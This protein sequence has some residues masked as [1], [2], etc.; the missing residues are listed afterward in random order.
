MLPDP[1][2][3]LALFDLSADA[4]FVHTDTGRILD[5]N[6]CACER[7]GYRLEELLAM[8]IDEIDLECRPGRPDGPWS[9]LKVGETATVT[10]LMQ[11]KDGV[12]FP[13]EARLTV[14]SRAPPG[15]FLAIVQ[16]TSARFRAERALRD[17]TARAAGVL[18]ACPLA[19]VS[20]DCEGRVTSWNRAAERLLGWTAADAVGEALPIGG[21]P[22]ELPELAREAIGGLPLVGGELELRRRDASLVEVRGW[23][24]TLASDAEGSS[25]AVLV[26]EDLTDRRSVERELHASYERFRTYIEHALDG[27]LV[28]DQA[29]RFVD[30]NPAACTLYGYTRDELLALGIPEVIAP[31]ADSQEAAR[32]HFARVLMTGDSRG[33]VTGLRKDGS[34]FTTEIRAVT[35]GNGLFLGFARDVTE[36][37][38]AE[39]QVRLF[40]RAFE[41]AGE[42]V[43]IT[44]A[45]RRIVSVNRAF[46]RITGYTEEEVLGKNP[47][48][49]ASGLHDRHFYELMWRT[50]DHEGRWKGEIWNR[51]KSG[52]V[53]P[54]WVDISVVKDALGTVESYIAIFSDISER[55]ASEERI[56]FLSQHDA[57]TQLPNRSLFLDRLHQALLHAQ[58]AGEHVGLL[59][60]DLDRFKHVNDS[61]GHQVGDRLL[62]AVAERLAGCLRRE[63]TAARV[64]GDEFA[65]VIPHLR[66]AAHAARV[67]E[68]VLDCLREP[69]FHSGQELCVTPSIGIAVYP[70]DGVE[71][72]SLIQGSDAAMYHVKQSGRNGYRFFAAD[73]QSHAFERMQ[74]ENELRHAI[75]DG[76]LTLHFQP[77]VSLVTGA[78]TGVEA[79]IRWA[80]PDRGLVPPDRFV[81]LAEE[82]GLVSR[83]GDWVLHTACE[84]LSRWRSAGLPEITVAV[85]VSA[86]QLQDVGIAARIERILSEFSVDPGRIELELTESALMRDVPQAVALVR[87][88]HGMGLRLAVDDF[89]TGYSNLAYL[90]RFPIGKLKIDKGFVMGLPDDSGD[91][92]IVESLI[93]LAHGLGQ[94]V[95]AEGV[96]TERQARF[97]QTRGCD[98]LQGFYFSRPV[99]DQDLQGML[100]APPRLELA[101]L[102]RSS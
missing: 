67:A 101:A 6:A 81:P 18:A 57:L 4:V 54:E 50:L 41:G 75:D 12:T 52:Q 39:R 35:L 26:F 73:M 14:V 31:D 34:T 60:I 63:D 76:Q 20:V 5:A 33:D 61:M 32:A 97:L 49:L 22:R 13:A 48:I 17:A 23:S 36:Q 80:H 77:Q 25:G 93:R 1:T 24:A 84:H 92:A 69:H 74:L 47:R 94:V 38:G 87:E 27:V 90:K 9:T 15:V 65:V 46:S 95:L 19:A 44:D 45:E 59:F 42:A 28:V 16:D 2:P 11:R 82:C 8:S 21:L 40:A 70:T 56:N 62:Q 102:A 98:F 100:R 83:V 79:L 43:L 78:I 72:N 89:G 64:G 66:Q 58:R 71:S 88:L 7:L 86:L 10:C 29:G 85:N 96:E 99:S 51:R 68:K 3:S 37:R 55:K 30:A 53:F 91:N